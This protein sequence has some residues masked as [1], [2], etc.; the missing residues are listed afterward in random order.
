MLK[1]LRSSATL[2]ALAVG[3]AGLV[4]ILYAWRLPPFYDRVPTTDNAYVRGYVTIISPQLSGYVTEVPVSDYQTVEAGDLL[5]Q[6]DQRIFE[7]KLK[8]AEATLAA[9]RA[10]LA[11]SAQ[12]ERSAQASI[13]SSEAQL[14]SAG[15]A[16]KRAQ[17][18][19]DRIEPLLDKGVV[20][21]SAGDQSR[22]T[23]T[24]ARAAVHQA[25]AALEMSRQQ[26]ATIVV[27]R[28]SLEA[29][30]TGAE[31]AARLAQIDLENTRIVAPRDGRLGE[32]GARVGQYVSAGTQLMAIVPHDVWVVA[33]FKETQVHGLQVGQGVSF[34]VDALQGLR[35]RGR[36]EHFSPAAG[37][38]FSVLRPDNATGNFTKIAQRISVRI[39]VDPDQA[40]VDRLIPGMSVVVSAD[41]PLPQ[42]SEAGS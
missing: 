21:Q 24:Q 27:G 6:L 35:I 32:V 7:Q 40:G 2:I 38:E 9:Q 31:A 8:Q 14:E 18:D 39:S 11:N 4:L 3:L 30:V 13:A 20:T 37:S 26:L 41:G 33:N 25:D 12:Q 29:A 34:T 16:L 5:V 1:A 28:G 19:W 23:L 42:E 15:A 22:A 36:I 10:A 17:A